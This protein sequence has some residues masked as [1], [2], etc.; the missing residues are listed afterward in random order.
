MS[1]LDRV[2]EEKRNRSDTVES[3]AFEP[4][5]RI[6]AARAGKRERD[7][8]LGGGNKTGVLGPVVVEQRGV[9]ELDV[10]WKQGGKDVCIT[11][12]FNKWA[13]KVPMVPKDG[14]FCTETVFGYGKYL[15][16]CSQTITCCYQFM[17]KNIMN[18]LNLL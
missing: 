17:I 7:V 10:W 9:F 11:G 16:H 2:E 1:T 12:N 6:G 5:G 3:V 15:T 8:W 4:D 14:A 13:E 18:H